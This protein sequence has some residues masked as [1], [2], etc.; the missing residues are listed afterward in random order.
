MEEK[1]K[2]QKNLK[3]KQSSQNFMDKSRS[4]TPES[5]VGLCGNFSDSSVDDEN[6]QM[7]KSKSRRVE[8]NILLRRS[9]SGRPEKLIEL[10]GGFDSSYGGSTPDQPKFVG[11]GSD[12]EK[13]VWGDN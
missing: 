11:D 8:P 2:P 13:Q 5:L 6:K 3:K 1:E 7:K 10:C 12:D 4:G 9:E